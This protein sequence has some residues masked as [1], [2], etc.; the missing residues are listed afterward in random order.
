M[1]D[2][3]SHVL[4]NLQAISLS[5]NDAI[6]SAG[7]DGKILTWNPAAERIFQY[8]ENELWGKSLSVI[9]PERYRQAHEMGMK[10]VA[11]GGAPHVIGKTVELAGLR[12]NGEEFPIELSLS[13][14]GVGEERFFAGIIRDISERKKAEQALIQSQTRLKEQAKKLRQANKQIRE[15]NEQLEGLSNK[16]AKYLSRQV[17]NSIF[18]GHRDVKIESY[19]KKL[20]VFFSDICNFSELTD[21][22]ESEVLTHLLNKYLNEMSKIAIEYGGTID[23]YIGDAIMIFF[24]DP[25][26]LGEKED[27][28]ACVK[29]A[30]A[31]KRKLAELQREWEIL[32]MPKP[33]Q[34]RMGINTGYCTVGNFGSD[35]RLDYT[36]VGGQVNLASRLETAAE[37]NQILISHETFSLIKDKIVCQK[38]AE[39]KMKG[40]AYP[41]QTYEVMGIYEELKKER[42]RIKKELAGFRLL[43]DFEKLNYSDKLAAREILENVLTHLT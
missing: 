22:I 14:W 3:I 39:L 41:V 33:L 43:I 6:I 15:K 5:S 11:A 28:L 25:E 36:I 9:I 1:K 10:R 35:E 30:L 29:M 4:Q 2:N 27:A 21:R 8:T 37:V 16:L 23:K 7:A 19:R 12:K 38:K 20:T 32:G 34:V 17:Y 31:M 18:N 24:G 26:T 13:T 40:I 42:E